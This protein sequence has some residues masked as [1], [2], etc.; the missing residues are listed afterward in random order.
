MVFDAIWSGFT[1]K[2]MATCVH[3]EPSV[4]RRGKCVMLPITVRELRKKAR[5][6]PRV[7]KRG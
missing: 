2:P 7:A 6:Y 3:A 5:Q 4:M 1:L